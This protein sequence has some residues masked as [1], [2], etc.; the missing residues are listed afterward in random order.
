MLALYAACAPRTPALLL[1]TPFASLRVG[2]T[3]VDGGALIKREVSINVS[4]LPADDIDDYHAFVAS[5]KKAPYYVD[6]PEWRWTV[7]A[8]AALAW[9]TGEVPAA[10]DA[11]ERGM[12]LGYVHHDWAAARAAFEDAT[13]ADPENPMAWALLGQAE[14]AT[15]DVADGL[16]AM[17]HQVDVAPSPSA[18]KMLAM[19]LSRAKGREASLEVWREAHRLY[20]GNREIGG[21]LGETLLFLERCED[22][23]PVLEAEAARQPHSS[24][25]FWDL[26]VCREKLGQ[27]AAATTAF[28]TAVTL[29]P[30]P[31]LWNGVAWQ[32][33]IGHHDLDK[34]STYIGLAIAETER[35]LS[36]PG[37]KPRASIPFVP[38]LS[39][40]WDT[41]GWIRFLGGDLE[42]AWADV[43][44]VWDLSSGN[45]VVADHLGQIAAARGDLASARR[46]YALALAG[47]SAPSDAAAHLAAI[48]PSAE[49]RDRAIAE[50]RATPEPRIDVPASPATPAGAATFLLVVDPAGNVEQATLATGGPPMALIADALRGLH[51]QSPVPDQGEWKLARVG[52][53]R[54]ESSG[55][56]LTLAP[57]GTPVPGD[58]PAAARR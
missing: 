22:A 58:Q 54:C 9:E 15:G 1:D 37:V 24:R 46:F 6:V 43:R 25:I 5:A 57:A 3:M 17:R 30:Q 53:V 56:S 33:A 38:R 29:E 41:R 45:G 35:Q 23:L 28:E 21:R 19:Q 20:P 49:A 7:G 55:C 48:E 32:L 4:E 10:R 52:T 11:N 31:A 27:P 18:Y 47:A 39:A 16:A 36:Q 34:A 42:G 12:V 26:G 50:A 14:M 2:V 13:H 8:D 40:Y 44:P 51:V